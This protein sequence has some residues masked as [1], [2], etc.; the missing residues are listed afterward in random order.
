MLEARALIQQM[1]GSERGPF[2]RVRWFCADGSVLPP[3]P[4]ACAEHGGGYQHGELSQDA[5]RLG[6]LG[7][8]VGTL[9]VAL[10]FDEFLDDAHN[11]DRL[12][13]IVL[14][15]HL[16]R[17]DDGWIERRSRYYR[18]ARQAEDEELAGREL[19]AELLSDSA[20]VRRHFLLAVELVRAIPHGLA[21]AQLDRMRELARRIG[22]ADPRF[23][24]LRIKIHSAP[25][26]GDAAT[27]E[28]LLAAESGLDPETR[29]ELDS[30]LVVLRSYY[31]SD[32]L[33]RLGEYLRREPF[34]DSEWQSRLWELQEAATRGS[35]SQ[36]VA[37]AGSMG[38]RLRREI[39]S[40][41]DGRS[42]LHRFDLSLSLHDL[43]VREAQA[44]HDGAALSVR[45]GAG[46]SKA[47][48]MTRLQTLRVLRSLIIGA[49]GRG[50]L[51]RRELEAQLDELAALILAQDLSATGYRRSVAYLQRATFWGQQTVEYFFGELVHDYLRVEPATEHFEDDLLRASVL[52]PLA[53]MTDDL[54]RDANLLLGVSHAIFGK[55]DGGAIYGL[56]P[57]VTVGVL[58]FVSEETFDA[59][60][61]D[62]HKIYVLPRS[63]PHLPPVG[64]ILT[65]SEGSSLSHLQLLA[66]SLG[67]PNSVIP[68]SALE[69]LRTYVGA[70][71]LYAVSPLGFVILKDM[72]SVS[73]ADLE[74]LSEQRL[75]SRRVSTDPVALDLSERRVISLD[76]IEIDD[77]GRIMGSKAAGVARLRRD[78]TDRVAPGLV[79]PYGVFRAHLDRRERRDAPSIYEQLLVFYHEVAAME[80]GGWPASELSEFVNGR[81]AYFRDEITR[82]ELDPGFVRELRDRLSEW[83]SDGS[84]GVFVRSD[85]NVEDLPEF[86]GAGLN[87]TV[88]NRT[89]FEDVLAAIKEVWA[90]P[91]TARAYAWRKSVI[92]T[93]EHTY[94]SVLIQRSVPVEKSGVMITAG[95]EEGGGDLITVSATEGS[96]GVV[97]GE[98]AESL[99]VSYDGRARLLAQAKAPS[100]LELVTDGE[101]GITSVPTSGSEFVLTR[102]EIAALLHL[103]QALKQRYEPELDSHSRP[104]PWDIEFGFLN[105][106]LRL[107]QIRPLASNPLTPSLPSLAEMD[108]RV[109][110]NGDRPVDLNRPVSPSD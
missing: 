91:F 2:A 5:R 61:F 43:V 50:L 60:E 23:Q 109:H 40:S 87:L 21:P 81:L 47:P 103:A 105:G 33:R 64:G 86:S 85:T 59:I 76:D 1:K 46:G 6:E 37:L 62:T 53:R 80:E 22:D 34:R 110:E 27:V 82:R 11:Y 35:A 31:D 79:I 9:Y 39:E 84:Y 48:A 36:V 108:A 95:L 38:A 65:L 30:L 83:V 71:V 45:A 42:N 93:P 49:Y 17:V 70:E 18:G 98:L 75:T 24:P 15:R 41:S 16:R 97:S 56:N 90:S 26:S 73:P 7:Y 58:E 13:E 67:I 8:H 12:R 25:D 57:G 107:F 14:Q 28:N 74:F 102:D 66:R 3:E 101:G 77:P 55:V 100:K 19:L 51:S 78:F 20:W 10:E 89:R 88:P 29:D 63:Y 52:L 4:H 96:V 106:E 99:Q 72:A 44:I 92:D 32:P 68:S 104:L 94:V 69:V 54:S